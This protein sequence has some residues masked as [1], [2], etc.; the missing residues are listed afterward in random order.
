MECMTKDNLNAV[1]CKGKYSKLK[2]SIEFIAAYFTAKSRTQKPNKLKQFSTVLKHTTCTFQTLWSHFQSCCM[3]PVVFWGVWQAHQKW[4]SATASSPA[5]MQLHP[6]DQGIWQCLGTLAPVLADRAVPQQ[7]CLLPLQKAD[8]QHDSSR[9][10]EAQ[11]RIN[12]YYS[13][14][15][16]Q[17][18]IVLGS[19]Q[20]YNQKCHPKAY[21]N[22]LGTKIRIIPRHAWRA[23]RNA[24]PKYRI[25]DAKK[26]YLTLYET[27]GL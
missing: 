17:E 19:V 14:S 18:L 3:F 9:T 5:R 7:T 12:L 26:L 10:R 6:W 23:L 11:V 27:S 24:G 21:S 2:L 15:T 1:C 4:C 25:S 13:R 8:I 20:T 22:I 16:N